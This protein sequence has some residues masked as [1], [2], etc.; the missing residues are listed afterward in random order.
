MSIHIKLLIG[1]GIQ[2]KKTPNSQ[3]S[4]NKIGVELVNIYLVRE[5]FYP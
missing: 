3:D 5:L 2:H 4:F 1:K